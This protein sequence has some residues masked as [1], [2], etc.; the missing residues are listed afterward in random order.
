MDKTLILLAEL[1]KESGH[2]LA[3]PV[4]SMG[5]RERSEQSS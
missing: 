4:V 1:E 2:Q 3:L 5:L